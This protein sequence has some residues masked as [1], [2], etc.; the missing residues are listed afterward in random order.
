MEIAG[1]KVLVTGGGGF[2]GSHIAEHL[3]RLGAEVSIMDTFLSGRTVNLTTIKDD[4]TLFKGDITNRWQVEKAM[5]GVDVVVETAFPLAA[6]DRSLEHQ[7]IQGG[8]TGLFNILRGA[9]KEKALVIFTS[10]IAVYGEQQY[11]PIDENH[12]LEPILLYGATK[13]AGE[14]YCQ[15]MGRTYGL[16][17]IILR[18][19]DIYG[20]RNGRISAPIHFL[21]Q[22]QKNLPV[23]LKGDGSQ[24]RTYTYISDLVDAV[25]LSIKCSQA[26]G[27]IINIAGDECVSV[28]RLAEL[29]KQVTG[30]EGEIRR[31]YPAACEGTVAASTLDSAFSDHR[32][33]WIANDKAKK[34]LGF[35]PKVD[36]VSGLKLTYDWLAANPDYFGA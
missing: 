13:L 2:L 4:I 18:I 22:G 11:L 35:Q 10:S 8:T 6:Y 24:S 3:V 33:Y 31:N 26:R 21:L 19:S 14:Y 25:L 20:P 5:Q 15:T 1:L 32:K 12:H 27:Q 16:N 23:E 9:V 28:Y 17:Y 29:C 36:M 30:S 7:F 34:L